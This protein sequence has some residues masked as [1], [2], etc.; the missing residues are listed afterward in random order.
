MRILNA[1]RMQEIEKNRPLEKGWYMGYGQE[2]AKEL[3]RNR[4]DLRSRNRVKRLPEHF[5]GF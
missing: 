5:E 1:K 4:V 3:Y 2:F